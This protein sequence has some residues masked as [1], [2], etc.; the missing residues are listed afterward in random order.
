[1]PE[2]ARGTFA[3]LLSVLCAVAAAPGP[4]RAGGDCT[5]TTEICDGIDNDCNG[6][7]DDGWGARSARVSADQAS[8]SVTAPTA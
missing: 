1:M 7:P 6:L 8:P 5:P 3:V 2:M 4:A